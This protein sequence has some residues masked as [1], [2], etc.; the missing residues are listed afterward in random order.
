MKKKSRFLDPKQ[1]FEETERISEV[2][3]DPLTGSSTRIL[4]FPIREMK[5]CDLGTL[6]EDS[7]EMCPFCPEVIDKV[8]PKFHPDLLS[9]ARYSKG[10]AICVPNAL[11]YDENGAVTV[12]SDKHHLSLKEFTTGIMSD[13]LVCCIEYL[14]DIVIKQPGV[15]YQSINWNY[16]PLAGGSIVH[17]HLQITASATP[18]NYYIEMIPALIQ[19]ELKNNS[20]FWH[21]IVREEKRLAQRYITSDRGLS[22]IVAFAPMG[23]FD[24]IGVLHEVKRPS[25]IS[26]GV[27]EALVRG[28]LKVLAY[29]DSLN[30]HSLNMSIYFLLDQDVFVPHVRICPRV[31]IGPFDTSQVNYMRMLHKETLTT[32][33]PEDVCTAI[34]LMW[35]D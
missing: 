11:P 7:K 13:A 32:I 12:I 1:G 10:K 26:G 21:D 16:M 25:D 28:I 34:K 5:P 19:Y 2:R 15:V 8:T 27:L 9:K 31:S 30:M 35:G 22:W 24:I 17:P 18:T 14:D 23:V 33:R 4:D 6:I 29:I 20:G 3:Y